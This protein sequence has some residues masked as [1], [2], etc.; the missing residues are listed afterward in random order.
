VL[1]LGLLCSVAAGVAV[2]LAGSQE[3]RAPVWGYELVST[4]PHDPQAFC[5]GLVVHE[6]KLY[7]G[8]GEYGSSSL[9]E[10]ELETGRVLRMFP[11]NRQFFGEGITLFGDSLYQLT[12]KSRRAFVFDAQTLEYQKTLQFQGEGWGLTHDGTH[13]IMS[14]GTAN[15]RFMDP[16]TFAE[17]RRIRVHDGR[18]RID[19]LNELEYVG[20]EIFANI[21][22]S[23]LI[24][25][26]SPEDGRVLG[27]IDLRTLW[28]KSERPSREAVLNGIAYD[29]ASGRLFV[30]GKN[31]PRL[32]EIR[33]VEPGG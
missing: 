13:L 4:F 15:L 21:W 23:D 25:R 33:L 19:K 28:P 18:R 1:A 10:V 3:S 31:W 24:A 7:E 5:Q 16:R 9:R 6:G 29:S 8:T 26:I 2:L 32:Y 20:G 27:W 17:V 30:T 22:Y 14:D 11:L 12:W